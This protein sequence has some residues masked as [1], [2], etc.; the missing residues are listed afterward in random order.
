MGRQDSVGDSLAAGR[1]ATPTT[2]EL[3]GKVWAVD[4]LCIKSEAVKGLDISRPIDWTIALIVSDRIKE[5]LEEQG[6]TGIKF[7]PVPC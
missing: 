2:E 6:T 3:I 7:A 5:A 1:G 4:N